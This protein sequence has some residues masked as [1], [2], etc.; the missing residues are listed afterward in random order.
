MTLGMAIYWTIDRDD[1]PQQETNETWIFGFSK[2]AFSEASKIFNKNESIYDLKLRPGWKIFIKAQS[3]RPEPEIFWTGYDQATKTIYASVTDDLQVK[4]VIAH[5]KIGGTYQDI[6]MTDNDGDTIYTLQ[7]DQVRETFGSPL[8][9][10]S[11]NHIMA[12]DIENNTMLSSI[13]TEDFSFQD[14]EIKGGSEEDDL[15]DSSVAAGDFN[16]D[17]YTDLAIGVPGETIGGKFNAG[18]VNILCGSSSGLKATNTDKILYQDLG[19]GDSSEPDNRFGF[20]V[21]AGDFNND[22]YTDLAIG[23]PGEVIEGKSNAGAVN[24]LYGSSSGLKATNTDKILYQNL[25][26]GDSSKRGDL[27]GFSVTAGDFNDDSYDDLAIGMPGATPELDLIA[28]GAVY[29]LNGSSSGLKAADANK[30][31]Y[32]GDLGTGDSS[33]R[34]DLFGFSVTASDFNNDSYDDLAIG[35]PGESI[36]TDSKAGAVNIL[37]GSS[38]GLKAA[39]QTGTGVW[40]QS[41]GI[42]SGSKPNDQFGLSVAAGDFNNDSYDDLAIGVP[43]EVIMGKENETNAGAVNIFYGSSSGITAYNDRLLYQ[44]QGIGGNSEFNDRFG[45]SLAAGDFNDD[46]Y[47]DLAIGVPGEAITDK[48]PNAG[49]VN[50]LYGS[51]SGLRAEPDTVK[52]WFQNLLG[53]GGG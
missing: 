9:K 20:S 41:K 14:P 22:N 12:K 6:N 3:D 27:F 4:S 29:V 26:I 21:A 39:V 25:G 10:D 18:A 35:V 34:G 11:G 24:V 53:I 7:L 45:T 2:E 43:G 17:S 16:N 48:E 32:Q 36:G 28:A 5:V 50:V 52:V 38:S 30:I 42:S 13:T 33:K 40:W 49:A 51:S 31:L 1:V 19:I 23:V 15:F 46:S 37:Y 44:D 47:D 8:L